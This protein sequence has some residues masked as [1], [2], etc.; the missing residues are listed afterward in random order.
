MCACKDQDT[1]LT[2]LGLLCMVVTGVAMRRPCFSFF[3]CL[4][5]ILGKGRNGEGDEGE[6]N[7]KKTTQTSL[8]TE[9]LDWERSWK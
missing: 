1:Y 3:H 7:E 6:G 4:K 5:A 8:Q 2:G 9:G